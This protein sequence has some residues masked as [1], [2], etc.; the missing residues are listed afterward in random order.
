MPGAG[1][2]NTTEGASPNVGGPLPLSSDQS[3]VSGVPPSTTVALAKSA[4]G[5]AQKSEGAVIAAVGWANTATVSV[6]SDVQVIPGWANAK[7]K[8]AVWGPNVAEKAGGRTDGMPE[9]VLGT[10]SGAPFHS[11]V[12]EAAGYPAGSDRS[13]GTESPAQ[14][15][16]K[17]KA[18]S[19]RSPTKRLA[20]RESL[21]PAAVVTVRAMP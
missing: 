21:Q 6:C 3:K 2:G 19:G 9:E 18:A 7:L 11:Q 14:T 20:V 13:S 1:D 15:G 8:A 17:A 12:A 5:P 10:V 16:S 4:S